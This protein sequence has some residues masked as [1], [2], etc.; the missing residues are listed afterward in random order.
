M[1]S[2]DGQQARANCPFGA[3]V[4]GSALRLA[5]LK[6]ERLVHEAEKPERQEAANAAAAERGP[7]RLSDPRLHAR[8]QA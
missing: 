3:T 8:E 5:E 7:W 6:L 2:Q 4:A 1:W